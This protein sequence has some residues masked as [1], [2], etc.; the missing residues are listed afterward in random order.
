MFVISGLSVLPGILYTNIMVEEKYAR[1]LPV[2]IF[3]WGGFFYIFGA[4]I[5]VKKFP[6]C[7]YRDT[8]DILGN[9]HNIWHVMVLI[10]SL[11]EWY[12]SVK[13]FHER[14]LYPCPCEL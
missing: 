2:E 9:S 6:E 12:G 3:L 4:F 13:V 1:A 5:F 7:W 11:F 10:G 8:F 14:I